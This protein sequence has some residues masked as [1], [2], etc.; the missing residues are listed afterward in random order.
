MRKIKQEYE[1]PIDNG[2]IFISETLNPLWKLLNFTPNTLTT[3]SLIFGLLAVYYLYKGHVWKFIIFYTISYHFDC[4]DGNYARTYKMT[5]K[6]GDLYDHYKD[7]SI[8]ILLLGVIIY[9]HSRNKKLIQ[10]IVI[11]IVFGHFSMNFNQKMSL[12]NVFWSFIATVA[13]TFLTTFW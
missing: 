3:L 8:F 5:T 7:V 12:F 1:N 10:V 2:F 6:F 9:K 4:N 11:L 13:C